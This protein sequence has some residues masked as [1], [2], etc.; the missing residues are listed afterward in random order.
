MR[1]IFTSQWRE[2][3]DPAIGFVVRFMRAYLATY[4]ALFIAL[5]ALAGHPHR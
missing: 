1:F 3:G 2:L 5:I 4:I